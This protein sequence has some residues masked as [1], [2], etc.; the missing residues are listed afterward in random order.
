MMPMGLLHAENTKSRVFVCI[1]MPSKSWRYG[2]F[3]LD[4]IAI[5]VFLHSVHSILTSQTSLMM[6]RKMDVNISLLC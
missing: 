2:V 4:P 6:F 1:D 3:L 5:V